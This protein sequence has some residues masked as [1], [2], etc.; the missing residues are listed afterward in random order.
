MS[1]DA[2][3]TMTLRQAAD[4]LG[5]HYMTVYRYVRLGVLTAQKVGGSWQVR[6]ADVAHLQE[7]ARSRSGVRDGAGDPVDPGSSGAAGTRA[8]APWLA[9][10]RRRML[11]G[12]VEGSWRV[13]ESAMA[14]GV[15]PADVHVEIL[16]PALHAIGAAWRRGELGI[17]QEHLASGVADSMVGRLG[18]RFR[19][20]GRR[21]GSIIVTMPAGERHGLGAAMVSDILR[22]EG[23]SVLNLGPDTPPASLVAAMSAVDDLR[24]VMVSVTDATRLPAAKRLIAAARSWSRTTPVIAGGFAVADHDSARAVGAD[25]WVADP[26]ELA[27]LMDGSFVRL[28]GD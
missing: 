24:A 5:V 13:I 8:K 1:A 7:Q 9:R 14:A 20:R 6:P 23:Y 2:S 27:P 17:E 15:A 10:L 16:A 22:G 28:S 26:R 25:G 3:E 21:R 19:R 12:D 4:L 18:P 11:A